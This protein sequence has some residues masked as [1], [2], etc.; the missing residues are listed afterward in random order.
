MALLRLKERHE[1]TARA[2]PRTLVLSA[3][4]LTHSRATRALLLADFRHDGALQR[5]WLDM[6]RPEP[7]PRVQHRRAEYLAVRWLRSGRRAG[8]SGPEGARGSKPRPPVRGRLRA[9]R[10]GRDCIP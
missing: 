2:A 7:M 5:G 6:P 1:R 9:V 8:T 3:L 4:R 10:A